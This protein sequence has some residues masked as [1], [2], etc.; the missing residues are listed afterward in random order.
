[1]GA[2]VNWGSG[3]EGPPTL[4]PAITHDLINLLKGNGALL[5]LAAG[6]VEFSIGEA[7]KTYG[8]FLDHLSRLLIGYSFWC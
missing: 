6:S 7:R 1:M 2:V 8:H 5:V 4:S 3:Q